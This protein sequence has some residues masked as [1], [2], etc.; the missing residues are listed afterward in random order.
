MSIKAIKEH[1][2][3]VRK[4]ISDARRAIGERQAYLTNLQSSE[5][6]LRA[7]FIAAR[8]GVLVASVEANPELVDALAP[9]HD[10]S[11]CSDTNIPSS[12]GCTRCNLL[13]LST[14]AGDVQDIGFSVYRPRS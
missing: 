9:Y 12:T 4:N 11:T 8:V 14:I 1:L 10:G 13:Q 7:K 5:E 6:S 3:G 2:S